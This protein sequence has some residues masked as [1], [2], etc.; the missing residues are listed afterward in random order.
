MNNKLWLE[1]DLNNQTSL[2]KTKKN[3]DPSSYVCWL[4]F[5]NGQY[6]VTDGG[7]KLI[8]TVNQRKMYKLRALLNT[9]GSATN[10]ANA[11]GSKFIRVYLKQYLYSSM[12]NFGSDKVSFC[13]LFLLELNY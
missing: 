3:T 2:N 9:K 1:D 4:Y 8:A 11:N 6:F 5:E 7:V 10:S 13:L 12:V